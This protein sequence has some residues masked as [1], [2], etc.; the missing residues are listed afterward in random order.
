[1]KRAQLLL[2][3]W[4]AAV[5]GLATPVRADTN[6]AI[7]K[8]YDGTVNFA[9]TQVTL[10]TGSNAA[11]PCSVHGP[12][13]T[14]KAT[15]SLPSG[16]SV[17]S[18]QLYWAGSGTPDNTV[19]F[20][21][22][23]VT[24]TR[25]YTA[26]RPNGMH[27]FGGAADVTEVVQ[28]NGA[29]E[30]RFSGLT[31][32]SGS[33]WCGSQAVLGGFAL[34]VVY[35]RPGEPE[36]VLNLYEG[37]RALQ[38]SEVSITTSNFRGRSGFFVQE[39]VRVGHLTW[40]GDPT[41]RDNE[42]LVLSSNAWLT[43]GVSLTDDLNPS[44]NQF[45]SA[46]SINGDANSW[47]IDFDV[48]DANVSY[49]FLP[50]TSVTVTYRTGQDLVLLNAEMVVMPTQAVSDLG[51]SIG[52]IGELQVG[53]NTRYTV[54]VTNNG[55]YTESGT[56]TVTIKLPDGVSFVSASGTGWS[57]SGGGQ[58][59]TCTYRGGLAPD[60]KAPQLAVTASVTTTGDKTTTVTVK[61][62]NKDDD[63]SNDSAS[64]TG[65]ASAAV[66]TPP[67]TP[68]ATSYVFTAGSCAVGAV[69]GSNACPR[70][71]AAQVAGQN[72]TVYVTAIDASG[73]ARAVDAKA[74]SAVKLR[75]ALG[76]DEP[77]TNAGVKASYAGTE[78]NLCAPAGQ[79]P[80]T[81]AGWS[82]ETEL[83]FAA[84]TPSVAAT[85]NY[86]D[87]GRVR[88]HL[89]QG[90]STAST[91]PFVSAPW[92]I[93]FKSVNRAGIEDPE[94]ANADLRSS[95]AFAMAGE[96]FTMQVG[97]QVYAAAVRYAP[98]FGRE[99]TPPPVS[100]SAGQAVA[101]E[102][103]AEMVWTAQGWT[104]KD[105][106]ASRTGYW[107]EAGKMQL[108]AQIGEGAA[109][110]TYLGV[111]GVEGSTRTVGRFYPAYLTT[112]VSGTFNCPASLTCPQDPLG[113][114]YS[115][116]PFGVKVTAYNA[117]DQEL[118]NYQGD[119][120]QETT[121]SAIDANGAAPAGKLLET[122]TWRASL[123]GTRRFQLPAEFATARPLANDWSAPAS[124]YI[125][126]TSSENV[127]GVAKPV[128]IGSSPALARSDTREGGVLVL[129]GRLKVS[130]AYGNPALPT[131]QALLPEYWNGSAWLPNP[132][133]GDPLPLDAGKAGF[134]C[135]GGLQCGAVKARAGQSITL[136]AGAAGVFWLDAPG[137]AAGMGS[138]D[139]VLPNRAWLPSTTGRV[140]FG[141]AR[142]ALIYVRE[143]Y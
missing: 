61:G 107:P 71:T 130:N 20:N 136:V 33:P 23:P 140:T 2:G 115:S 5:L 48:H 80:S 89:L 34:L 12:N 129:G 88:L 77:S 31:V 64:N 56:V 44:G 92:R 45:N 68:P 143:V 105:G 58:A 127:L 9:G 114:T 123:E 137:T 27:Y 6:L 79:T 47:G 134:A 102:A 106:I 100:V 131:R 138:V 125:R 18:A 51:I 82:S 21:D 103:A 112:E 120:V 84:G 65:K 39:K 72:S 132:G 16:A 62:S 124:V 109:A 66:V 121:L 25:K 69:F 29:G 26:P 116:Q 96:E 11:S 86:P 13:V 49:L 141:T 7:W 81:A 139:V 40:E 43:A 104:F 111:S 75:F 36:R 76:C 97:A 73:K 60:G 15:L 110:G 46:S 17:L 87:V 90:S 133:Y 3:G 52:R 57:C 93:G 10:R 101:G 41:L 54:D 113:A 118:K 42:D 83:R 14:R 142:G 35:S 119:W 70:Y 94:G 50:P 74:Q 126:A 32:S 128:T 117:Q 122:D 135:N 99:S 4:L 98:N 37:L 63:A 55:P 19:S 1:M 67:A 24:A 91:E 8:T 59:A 30:Y 85:F 53:Q 78:L 28:K 38:N 95:A 108:A 22:K